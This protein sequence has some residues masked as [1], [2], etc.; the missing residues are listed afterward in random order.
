[1]D[2]TGWDLVTSE[3]EL[4]AVV[5]AP[6]QRVS[7]KVA[8]RLHALHCAFLAASPLWLLATSASDGTCNVSPKGDPAGAVLVLDERTLALPDRPGNRRVDG[9]EDLL[10]NPHVGL[11]FLVPG[12][13]DTLRINGRASLVKEAPFF[14][15]LRVEG[16]RPSLAVVVDVEEV[17]FHCAKAFLRSQLWDPATWNPDAVPSR[18][19]IAKALD[20]PDASLAE[21]QAYYGPSYGKDLY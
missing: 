16:K 20:R 19:Q 21:L 8:D 3:Q 18:A 5:D 15:R 9:F 10:G 11:V 7:D 2:R 1:M 4:R 12:R 13:G 6:L 17:F 14:D